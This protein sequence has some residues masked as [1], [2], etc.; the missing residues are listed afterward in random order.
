MMKI[1]DIVQLGIIYGNCYTINYTLLYMCV[2]QKLHYKL[3]TLRSYGLSAHY[4][5]GVTTPIIKQ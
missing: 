5:L 4:A 3:L 1:G 2:F